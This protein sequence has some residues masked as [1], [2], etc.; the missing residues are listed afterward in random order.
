MYNFQKEVV[1]N[2]ADQVK[3]VVSFTSTLDSGKQGSID[4]KLII[5][6]G[7]EYY[8]KYI[9]NGK[10]Y[11]TEPVDGQ[12]TK[13]TIKADPLKGLHVQILI[14]LGLDRDYRGDYG[15]ALWYFRKPML[16]DLVL[17]STK[18]DAAA[19]LVKAFK[20][21]IPD[22]YK[23]ASVSAESDSAKQGVIIEGS[24]CYIK[25]RKIV[26]SKTEVQSNGEDKVTELECFY[27]TSALAAADGTYLADYRK[28]KVEVG[29]Y[30][31]ML[32][33]LRLPTY[34]NLRFTSPSVVEMPIKGK[35]YTQY[36]FEYCVPRPGLGG[37]SAVGQTTSST[38]IHTFYVNE[39]VDTTFASYFNSSNLNMTVVT[40]VAGSFNEPET[41]PDTAE[42][43]IATVTAGL[44][45]K[46]DTLVS[47]TNI[48][49]INE[50]DILGSGN[51][52]IS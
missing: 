41:L 19:Q 49:T 23:F 16:V 25:I 31:Y 10:V 47:G 35:K 32:H 50:N 40:L 29:T 12:N 52:T 26:I 46:Q 30:D 43:A 24:D 11:K 14:E 48:K 5:H 9:V 20:S 33:N 38:T 36:S 45:G 17:S 21:V 15:S 44:N 37:L 8:G 13:V 42:S 2:N 28:N 7:G 1:I 39:D 51:I 27:G 3:G 4:K 6:D 34:E 22:D 18:A